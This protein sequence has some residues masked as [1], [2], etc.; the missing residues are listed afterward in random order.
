M[1][2]SVQSHFPAPA[3]LLAAPFRALGNAVSL[4]VRA[5]RMSR[6]AEFMLSLSD[7][8]LAKRGLTRDDIPQVLLGDR[9]Y[10]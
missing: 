10:L 3:D 6:E 4:V 8:E 1:A 7:A 2:T 9:H 5:N